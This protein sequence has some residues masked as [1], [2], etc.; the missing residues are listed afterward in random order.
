MSFSLASSPSSEGL[1][2][3][4]EGRSDTGSL[5]DGKK[6]KLPFNIKI[7]RKISAQSEFDAESVKVDRK[8]KKKRGMMWIKTAHHNYHLHIGICHAEQSA[9]CHYIFSKTDI[10]T[11]PLDLFYSL[12]CHSSAVSYLESSTPGAYKGQNRLQHDSGSTILPKY[13][14]PSC[15]AIDWRT[16]LPHIKNAPKQIASVV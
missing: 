14:L 11:W 8:V 10:Q 16:S 2:G 3:G 5:M 13:L 12:T 9:P 1:G 6:I 7:G 15:I 4:D